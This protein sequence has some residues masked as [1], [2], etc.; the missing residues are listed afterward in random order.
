MPLTQQPSTSQ[1]RESD[2]HPFRE[3]SARLIP[4]SFRL[5]ATPTF[6][7]IQKLVT[8]AACLN[9]RNYAR[10]S[11]R[12]VVVV[13]IAASLWLNVTSP[14]LCFDR[15]TFETTS[16]RR[17]IR[18]GN[19]RQESPTSLLSASQSSVTPAISLPTD[20]FR[21]HPSTDLPTVHTLNGWSSYGQVP[22]SPTDHSTD[23][24]VTTLHTGSSIARPVVIDRAGSRAII[25]KPTVNPSTSS[26]SLT[27]IAMTDATRTHLITEG[28][29]HTTPSL[30]S[31]S[32]ITPSSRC[33]YT[34]SFNCCLIALDF[35][36][37]LCRSNSLNILN[38]LVIHVWR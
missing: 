32:S 8:V 17:S 6:E 1:A 9:W 35:Y 38:L 2:H 16:T 19:W 28:M 29:S 5:G 36:F 10:V 11:F 15:F 13:V 14:V 24:P 22:G 26:D 7:R 30:P 25:N 18:G 31:L 12:T 34:V 21:A 33:D 37:F 23:A 20:L 3:E 27:A 4:E